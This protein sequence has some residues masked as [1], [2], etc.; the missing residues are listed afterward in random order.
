[1]R[2][3]AERRATAVR[4]TWSD[5]QTH[6]F[7]YL[8]LRD[9][10]R[11]A[12]CRDPDAG[13]RLFNPIDM[14]LDLQARSVE[15]GSAL[16]VEWP[17]GHRTELT[18]DWLREHRNG[19][20]ATARRAMLAGE[21]QLWGAEIAESPPEIDAA[22]IE[23]GPDGL[24]RWMRLVRTYGFAL[25]RELPTREDA[26]LELAE[27]IAFVQES[28]FGRSF[29]V[30]SKPNPENLAFTAQRLT[31]HTDIVNR[32]S[33]VNLQFLHCLEFEAEGGE[34]ILVDGFAAATRLAET[35]AEAHELLREVPVRWR[36]RTDDVD[37]ANRWPVITTDSDGNYTE[38]R[39][40]TGLMEPLEI[41]T[42]LIP[43]FYRALAAF[44]R[45]LRDPGR[46]FVF[47]MHPGDCQ[48]F[49]NQ[50][51]LHAR[52]A[53]DPN[54]GTRRLHGC[55]VDKDDFVGRL[56]ALERRPGRLRVDRSR[57]LPAERDGTVAATSRSSATGVN[58]APWRAPA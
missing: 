6:E 42:S 46:E 47:K 35:D 16:R 15:G 56:A 54:S 55:Y 1:M 45:I 9:N 32:H 39:L 30:V 12:E 50:R 36:F 20:A 11:C 53:F 28:N 5:G 44:G 17:G 26:V 33:A 4:V 8:W 49:D 24:L 25:I 13:E 57:R 31:A 58:S 29:H 14:P 41:E 52:A 34:S 27:R 37:I 22:E 19:A 51:V 2:L 21:L 38:I 48:V 23:A 3:E 7:A 43:D 40:N 10:C 18:G